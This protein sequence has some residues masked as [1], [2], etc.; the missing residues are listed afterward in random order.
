MG[1]KY[2]CTTDTNMKA[3]YTHQNKQKNHKTLEK[4]NMKSEGTSGKNRFRGNEMR[5]GNKRLKITKIHSIQ[6]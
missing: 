1:T 3:K 5:E 2:K 4:M 6:V